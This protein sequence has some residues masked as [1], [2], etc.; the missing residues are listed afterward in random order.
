MPASEGQRVDL[1]DQWGPKVEHVRGWYRWSDKKKLA[2]IRGKIEEWGKDPR[3][4][5]FVVDNVLRPAGVR[6]KDYAGQARALLAWVQKNIYYVNEPAERLQSPWRTIKQRMGDCDDMAIL[7]GAMAHSIALPW[8]LAIAGS[9]PL[10]GAV[11]YVEGDFGGPGFSSEYYHI[12]I[13]FGIKGMAIRNP[14]DQ[15]WVSAEPTMGD[16]PLGFD[17]VDAERAKRAR[18]QAP[19]KTNLAGWGMPAMALQTPRMTGF[20]SVSAGNQSFTGREAYGMSFGAITDY[21]AQ[22]AAVL[23]PI[24]STAQDIISTHWKDVTIGVVQSVVA[25]LIIQRIAKSA[26]R[27]GSR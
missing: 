9:H 3:L 8:K 17:V 12:Y 11:R 13:R 16:A 6:P 26:K 5:Y 15:V 14:K 27:K 23:A 22:A 1:A 10:K 24:T 2:Y 7:L 20:G 25:M 4:A 21:P 18:G 19:S